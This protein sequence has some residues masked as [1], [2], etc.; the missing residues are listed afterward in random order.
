MTIQM[1]NLFPVTFPFRRYQRPNL[2]FILTVR[3]IID[4]HFQNE[5]IHHEKSTVPFK[6]AISLKIMI[7]IIKNGYWP[8]VSFVLN[9]TL[10]LVLFL[11]QVFKYVQDCYCAL[12]SNFS[13]QYFLFISSRFSF[14]LSKVKSSNPLSD[15]TD[16]EKSSFCQ[17]NLSPGLPNLNFLL[18]HLILY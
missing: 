15:K 6:M 18:P 12:N 5:S 2:F 7:W 1:S 9:S 4:R 3:F 17:I 13:L 14:S 11:R 10:R 16:L 8:A